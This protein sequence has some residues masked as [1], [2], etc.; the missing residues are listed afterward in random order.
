MASFLTMLSK[1]DKRT[2]YTVCGWIRNN[3]KLLKL[4]HI[5]SLIS[6]ICILY[7][8]DDEIFVTTGTKVKLSN[9]KKCI[10][11]IA[12]EYSY[13]NCSYGLIEISSNDNIKCQ[14]DLKINKKKT[15]PHY[16]SGGFIIMGINSSKQANPDKDC[17]IID[18]NY[19]VCSSGVGLNEYQSRIWYPYGKM[20]VENDK[21]S[22]CLDLKSK[23]IRFLTNDNDQGVAFNNIKTGN[24]IKYRLCVSLYAQSIVEIVN[25]TK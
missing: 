4:N 1:I 12:N 5:P 6:C 21:V 7:F 15:H 2:K 19:Y 3:E 8:R 25:F 20:W 11:K 13:S 10:E 22:L 9:N 16:P 23:Q 24:D 17:R 14:W 18:A